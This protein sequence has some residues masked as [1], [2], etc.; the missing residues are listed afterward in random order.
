MNGKARISAFTAA[1]GLL[2]GCGRARCWQHLQLRPNYAKQPC[3]LID[4]DKRFNLT[5]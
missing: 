5:D 2:P 3:F 1:E 4:C